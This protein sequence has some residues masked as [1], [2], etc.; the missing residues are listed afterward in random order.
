[1]VYGGGLDFWA[2]RT[3]LQHPLPGISR[4]LSSTNRVCW[5]STPSLGCLLEEG[6]LAAGET[7]CEE[8]DVFSTVVK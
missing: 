1:M 6:I 5:M 3:F 2:G 4:M 8:P 7:S